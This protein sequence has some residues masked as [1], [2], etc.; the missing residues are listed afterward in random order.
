MIKILKFV[1]GDL[2]G[3]YSLYSKAFLY[4]AGIKEA[5]CFIFVKNYQINYKE[6]VNIIKKTSGL[7][8]LIQ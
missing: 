2:S 7:Y 6:Q 3:I 8:K 5:L 1:C 4:I